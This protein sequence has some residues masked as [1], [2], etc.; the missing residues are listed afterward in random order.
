MKRFNV[1]TILLLFIGAN[2]F[3]QSAYYDAQTLKSKLVQGKLPKDSIAGFVAVL[4]KYLPDS[5]KTMS[6]GT[7]KPDW[8]IMTALKESKKYKNPFLAGF[9]VDPGTQH[10]SKTTATDEVLSAGAAASPAGLTTMMID[11]M[12]KFLVKRTKEEL[13]TAFFDE[14]EKKLEEQK[15]LQKF[16]PSTFTILRTAK[17]EIYNYQIYLPALQEAFKS[18]LSNFL[19]NAYTWTKSTDG[20]LIQHVQ[21]DQ[22]L[23]A[24]LKAAFYLSRELDNGVHPGDILNALVALNQL[25]PKPATDNI[26]FGDLYENLYPSLQTVNLFS[27][28]LRTNKASRYWIT[29]DEFNAFRSEAFVNLYFGL[30]YQQTKLTR[31]CFK[32]TDDKKICLDTV[33]YTMASNVNQLRDALTKIKE[34]LASIENQVNAIRNTNDRKASS[35]ITLAQTM[36]VSVQNVSGSAFAVNASRVDNA[37]ARFYIDHL[38]T[39]WSYIESKAYNSA[40]FEAYVVLDSA[41]NNEADPALKAFLKYGTFMATVAAA[42]SSDEV[43][44]AIE[45]IVLPP[46]SSSIKRRAERNVALNAYVG[47]AGGAEVID[48]KARFAGGIT[49]PIGL[50]ISNGANG[51]TKDGKTVYFANSLFISLVDLGAVT[52]YRFDDN[53]TAALPELKFSNIFAPGLYYVRGIANSPLSYGL[54]GQLGPQLRKIENTGST[55]DNKVNYS[56]KVFLAVDI[57]LLNFYTKTK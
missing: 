17:D 35:Y 38:S 44:A 45:A 47:L 40:V 14:F 7:P 48:T 3:S 33:L 36:A 12:A 1:I 9:I 55:I 41:L 46:G 16:F 54:G 37:A 27:Q 19:A 52:M 15:D 28:S 43:E 21:K 8:A 20:K 26:D 11:G 53:N 39:L 42:Q 10:I 51:R 34:Q 6:D 50:T 5:L 25:D 57:P 23:Y 30:I 56:F 4:K 13:N 22:Q 24:V 18:D 2:A 49:A 29:E 32:K 31:I